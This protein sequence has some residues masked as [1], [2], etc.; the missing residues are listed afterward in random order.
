MPSR[1]A[2]L[3]DVFDVGV[4]GSGVEGDAVLVGTPEQ[5]KDFRAKIGAVSIEAFRDASGAIAILNF[6]TVQQS[7]PTN[8]GIYRWLAGGIPAALTFAYGGT[9]FTIHQVQADTLDNVFELT[10]SPALERTKLN[11]DL[12]L[13]VGGHSLGFSDAR[14]QSN[15]GDNTR[16]DYTWTVSGGGLSLGSN[17]I[18]IYRQGAPRNRLNPD[19]ENYDS[20]DTGN[21]PVWDNA[22]GA[23]E[24]AEFTRDGEVEATF[25]EN[26]DEYTLQL[27]A[28]LTT[29]EK[30]AARGKL[31]VSRQHELESLAALPAIAG[32]AVGNIVDVG[33]ELYVLVDETEDSN[34]HRGT[35]AAQGANYLGDD[36]FQWAPTAESIAL[37]RLFIPKTI[38]AAPAGPIYFRFVGENGY[39][40]QEVPLN[41]AAGSDTATDYAY[42]SGTTGDRV[43]EVPVGD[44]FAVYFYTDANLT[45][46]LTIHVT[47]RW[48]RYNEIKIPKVRYASDTTDGEITAAQF[49]KFDADYLAA[50]AHNNA[51]VGAFDQDSWE[52]APETGANAGL[53][54]IGPQDSKHNAGIRT[55]ASW[56]ASAR[57]TAA[58][59]IVNEYVAFAVPLARKSEV[60]QRYRLV[61]SPNAD[62][63]NPTETVTIDATADHVVDGVFSVY[64]ATGDWAFYSSEVTSIPANSYYVIQELDP[65]LVSPN[66]NFDHSAFEYTAA[67]PLTLNGRE[68]GLNDAA[69]DHL[70][71]GDVQMSHAYSFTGANIGNFQASTQ[72]FNL[73]VEGEIYGEIQ[74]SAFVMPLMLYAGT[75]RDRDASAAGDTIASNAGAVKKE[76]G[77]A[78]DVYFARTSSNTLLVGADAAATFTLRIYNPGGNAAAAQSGPMGQQAVSN[79]DRFPTYAATLWTRAAA[80][81][82]PNSGVGFSGTRFTNWP[83]GW[84]LHPTQLTGND[85]LVA[86]DN[87]WQRPQPGTSGDWT[88]V[89]RTLRR[90]IEFST[91]ATP[92]DPA[93]QIST[94]YSSAANF[95]KAYLP[96]GGDTGWIP[97]GRIP[98]WTRVCWI[99]HWRLTSRA[100]TVS[101]AVG[102]SGTANLIDDEFIIHMGLTGP[103]ANNQVFSIVLRLDV[104]GS[105]VPNNTTA[106]V[107]N[108]TIAV[109]AFVDSHQRVLAGIALEQGATYNEGQGIRL[110]FSVNVNFRRGTGDS[111]QSGDFSFV[112]LLNP[113]SWAT[114]LAENA[115]IVSFAMYRRQTG[116]GSGF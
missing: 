42:A 112:D 9:T 77:E 86:E 37:Q 68:F 48:E 7:G 54:A 60:A 59:A 111:E 41:R 105:T 38:G 6:T 91:T 62:G 1:R 113:S 78:F 80:G 13:S 51:V 63:S 47:D 16:W 99:P 32:Y 103:T 115:A 44:S 43:A 12:H 49:R 39:V 14:G 79:Y 53:L 88:L 71:R 22:R 30:A 24:A 90:A 95:W 40:I 5:K 104:L 46:P 50:N 18:G 74:T 102:G 108:S 70:R 17:T 85:P 84:S 34:V 2:Y 11:D 64:S 73:P 89:S 15:S 61:V 4:P 69:L 55:A 106:F 20:A 93:T 58:H 52:R 8:A 28:D 36:T 25:D 67:S 66:D 94:T 82:T 27:R 65:D 57:N 10:I 87:V 81:T 116:V 92:T 107:R 31:D 75:L 19:P 76:V 110:P 100:N 98:T 114:A 101:Q 96:G 83:V 29:A 21:F 33:G 56:A 45:V 23:W 26:E 109:N 35:V 3:Q 97:I 72:V